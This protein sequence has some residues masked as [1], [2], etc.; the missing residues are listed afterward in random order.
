MFVFRN[1][2]FISEEGGVV[3]GKP[4]TQ[5]TRTPAPK[6]MNIMNFLQ[7]PFTLSIYGKIVRH[8]PVLFP[9]IHESVC[10]QCSFINTTPQKKTVKPLKFSMINHFQKT[11][12]SIPALAQNLTVTQLHD[13][14]KIKITHV[15]LPIADPE[16]CYSHK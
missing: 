13:G 12:L 4:G 3:L 5:G 16:L 2:S 15:V 1:Q 11:G 8:F 7:P 14:C 10:V 6:H 9:Q